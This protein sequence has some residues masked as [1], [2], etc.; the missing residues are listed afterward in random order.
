MGVP[1][2]SRLRFLALATAAAVAA[3]VLM[4]TAAAHAD[5]APPDASLPKTVAADSLPT[6][7]I[8][9]VVWTQLI[10]GNT[11]YVGGEFTR[12]RPAG[13]AAGVN[14]VARTNLMAYNLT[15]GV[16]TSFNPNVN[17][18]VR[19]LVASPDGTRVYAGGSFTS[20]GGV[21]RY[22]LA[23]F[24][25]ATGALVTTW[26]PVVNST[27]RAL[28][29]SGSTV[30]AG[31]VFTAANAVTRTQIA[32]FSTTN[33][34]LLPWQGTPAGGG[35]YA[36]A[37]S[38]D[39][40]KVVIGGSFT[41]YNGGTDP[42]YGMAAT[43]ASTGAPLPWKVNGL[44]R[45]GGVNGA[46]LSL[47]SSADGVFG[48]GYD[49]GAGAMFEGTFRAAWA[50]GTLIWIED[51]HGDTYSA[52]PVNDVVYTTG[53][54]HYCG[55]I[56]GYPETTPRS[57]HRTLAFS[58]KT[59]GVITANAAGSYYNF[60]GSPR[61][62]L[63]NWHPDINTGTYTGQGQGPWNVAGNSQ[64]VLY[65][66]EFTIVNNK[67]QQGLSRFAVSTIAPNKEGPRVTNTAFVSSA[68]VPA[69]VS[70]AAGSARVSWSSA[71]DR[72][73]E[74][75]KYEVLRDG[76]SVKT[77]QASSSDWNRLNLGWTDTGLTPGQSYSYRI[78]V[79]DPFGNARTGD[80]ATVTISASGSASAY[81]ALVQGDARSYWP[82]GE[83]G[84]TTAYDWATGVDATTGS[85][86]TGNVPGAITGTTGTASRFD[87]TTAGFASTRLI[88]NP[89]STFSVEAWVKTTTK[90]GGK[91][92]G[93][94]NSATG[95]STSY[96]RHVY[97]DTSG[98]IWFGVRPP[99]GTRTVNSAA[100]YNDGKWH[101]IVATL[102]AQGM[103]LYIDGKQSAQR[104][105]T[106]TAQSYRGYWR[107]G[108]D[109]LNGWTG[110][111]LSDYIAADIDEVALYT[112]A[113]SAETVANHYALATTGTPGNLA[114][115][116]AFS[117]AAN[118]L[119]VAVDGSASSDP[120]GTI[121]GYAWAFG[122]GA[123]A[124]GPTASH[125]YA[126]AGTYTV[127][128]TVT[129]NGGSTGT[130]THQVTVAQAP[131]N[132][133]PTAVLTLTPTGLSVAVDG[134]GST[135]ADGTIAGYAW[136]FGDGGTGTG[137]TDTHAYA[138]AGTYTV[139]L[140]VT[141]NAGATGVA[142][143]Q[144]TVAAPPPAGA[145]FAADAFERTT[146]GGL[147]TADTGGPWTVTGSS[148]NYSVGDGVGRLRAATAGATV[149]A[150]LANVSSSDADVT[151]TISLQDQVTGSG[152]YVSVIGRR[153][154]S[155]DYRAR[156]KV[157]ATGVV[158]LQLLHGATNLQTVTLAGITYATGDRLQVRTQ[159]F[160]TSPTTVRAKAWPLG[161]AEPTGWQVSVTD[162]TD[163][164][165]GP[166]HIGFA[167][168]LGGT[169]TVVPLTASFDDLV[170][171]PVG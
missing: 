118:E 20:V 34:A 136:A 40:T 145:A 93:F 107:I 144:V 140:T 33:G 103:V 122:D 154:G 22:R 30:Y 10:V 12:A 113:I 119:A 24:T 158:Q 168:Y 148:A 45:N 128:L 160:G 78:R 14:E 73:N 67:G 163:T 147:G 109:N 162:A 6:P 89:A 39:G 35:V 74:Q 115:T 25:A 106:T 170:A 17:G 61:P 152:A 4:G 169:A 41:S 137:A 48:T 47:T 123:T 59:T 92:I 16:M 105:D 62:S 114:P 97:M 43:N 124:A 79:T 157:L 100:G 166:G 125:T 108:G 52:A 54:V 80:P 85:G 38:P 27:V 117:S 81:S 68:F 156:V 101:Q 90:R 60:A 13:S 7:Q 130:V 29:I 11:V 55:N 56:D 151:A 135:D 94:G 112:R 75:L 72:D 31:G 142:T 1:S 167:L 153:I 121:T 104:T 102:G 88:E 71:Y 82:F 3:G 53:H 139:T 76:V 58:M 171:R 149:N 143:R 15:T 51:C 133:T 21:N 42:G 91:I 165:Q 95:A 18:A 69:V 164:M 50:D 77:L 132:A 64:Y 36:L 9:G 155:D 138:A 146:T 5:T 141:D 129:D 116:A 159:V 57:Y 110:R 19:A 86:V 32:S 23:A 96:D 65:G 28:G 99:A 70:L 120:D 98:R 66:G 126:A 49:F 161:T 83:A 84:G 63:L 87:G 46:I 134:S 26:A 8:N 131:A 150:Y 111:P 2:V 37:V 127:S 44:I